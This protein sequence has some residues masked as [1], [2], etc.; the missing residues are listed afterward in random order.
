MAQHDNPFRPG[1][2]QKPLYLAGRDSEQIKFRKLLDQKPVLRN[3]IITGL[4][5]V[6]KTVLLDNLKPL[7]Q[8][9]KWLWTGN[10]LSESVS[11]SEERIA[12]RVVADLSQ[13]LTPIIVHHSETLA[14]GFSDDIKKSEKPISFDDLWNVYQSTPGLTSDKLKQVLITAQKLLRGTSVNGIV[15]AYDEA[16]NLSDHAKEGEYPLSVL[17]D[18]FSSLQK[19]HDE[20]PILLILTGLPT[21]FPR[22][23]EA[24]TYTERMFEVMQLERLSIDACRLA[25]TKPIEIAQS[26][27]AFG[28]NVVNAVTQMSGGYPYFI[29]YICREVFDA[30][31]SRIDAG[32]SPSVDRESII[33]KLDMDFF[34]PRWERT[35]VRQQEFMQVI[36][37]LGNIDEGFT[38]QEVATESGEILVK[39]FSPSHAIQMLQALSDKGLI[40]RIKYGKYCFAVPLMADFIRRQ[41]HKLAS[42][43]PA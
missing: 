22:L 20:I 34:A 35:T 29:Q 25:I 17:L 30:W 10:D 18:V 1:A 2:G 40:Y 14:F 31:I 42:A 9:G 32:E 4:R 23:N 12:T 5:G 16:Q 26:P 41:Q 33:T 8:K 19:N 38:A 28:D 43:N 36:S 3:L 27:L 21:L 6:G 24:R 15:F 39:K 7:A 13:L 37:C 11:L